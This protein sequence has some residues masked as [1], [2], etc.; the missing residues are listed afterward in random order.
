MRI[1]SASYLEKLCDLARAHGA[2]LIFDEVMTGFGRTGTF[3]AFEQTTVKPDIICV[4]KGITGGTLPLAAT[5]AR[6]FVFDKFLGDTFQK[7]LAHG[8]SYTANPIACAVANASLDLFEQNR[9][10][11]KVALVN[12][13]YHKHFLPVCQNHECLQ[14]PRLLGDVA[15]VNLSRP[16]H[17]YGGVS[18]KDLYRR[19]Q[20]DGLIIR[21]MGEVIYLLPPYCIE[22]ADIVAACNGIDASLRS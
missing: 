20:N 4:S 7:A 22:E 10:L 6:G 18:S 12:S 16:G 11:E 2:L 19:Y 1:Y 5:L 15:A 14:K 21:P 8:H 17:T 13:W 3:F 9:C